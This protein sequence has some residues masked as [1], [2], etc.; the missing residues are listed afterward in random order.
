[1]T[2]APFERACLAIFVCLLST[3]T[4]ADDATAL[5][6]LPESPELNVDLVELGRHLFFEPKLSGDGSTWCASCHNPEKGWSDGLPLSEGYLGTKYFRRSP[7]IVNASLQRFLYWDGRMAGDDLP[8]LVRDHISEA[9]FMQA[10]GRLVIE[11]LRQVPFY[12]ESFKEVTGGEVSY[13]RILNAVSEFVRSLR[14][15]NVP[16]DR[17]IAGDTSAISSEARKGL[18]LFT[19]KARCVEC[20]YGPLLSDQRFHGLGV[21]EN[22]DVFKNPLRHITYRR[23]L[24]TFGVSD[25]HLA[26]SDR[27]LGVLTHEKNDEGK[28]RTPSLREV[29]RSD[30]FMHNG[31][32]ASLNEVIEFYDRGGYSETLA[33][34][35]LSQGEKESLIAFLHSLSGDAIEVKVPDEHEY[36]E[37]TLGEN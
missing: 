13:G 25:Y 29:G 31:A 16:F 28:F 23:F 36:E 3:S 19:G 1:M 12:E 6:P 14:S 18:A 20:H 37:R 11:R 32:F 27:G 34:L 2:S 7:S 9:H 17:Y 30:Y 8:T 15:T 5:A 22:R 4:N 24:K 26:R 10:D 21:P 35:N 33:P